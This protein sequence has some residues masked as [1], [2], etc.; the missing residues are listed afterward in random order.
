M[1]HENVDIPKQAS[2]G[3]LSPIRTEHVANLK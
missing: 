3:D 2:L 1:E